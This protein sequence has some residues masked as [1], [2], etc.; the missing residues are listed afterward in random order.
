MIAILRTDRPEQYAGVE[1][2]GV[3]RGDG[4]LQLAI[5]F[6]VRARYPATQQRS[7]SPE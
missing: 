4:L 1:T 3:V 7:N 5:E 6:G 2:G